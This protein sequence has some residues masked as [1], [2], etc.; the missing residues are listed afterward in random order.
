[1]NHMDANRTLTRYEL[2]SPLARHGLAAALPP[3]RD[4]RLAWVNSIC[5]LFLLTG[6][7]GYKR[8]TASIKPLTPIDDAVPAV[9]E[10]LPP[11]PPATAEQPREEPPD[12]DKPEVPQVVAVTL[13]APAINFS[14]PTI[15][16]LLV[17]NA[18][19]QAPPV[20]PLKPVAPL[21]SAPRTINSTGG[22]G[23]RPQPPYPKIA[24]EQGQ[25]GSVTLSLKAD[26]AG[27]ITDIEVAES[28]G[29]P[30]LD[31]S[32][33]E[34]VKHH[35]VVP[36]GEGARNYHATIHYRLKPD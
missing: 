31:R 26:D 15:G 30:L 1:M 9:V 25:Q 4:R 27:A 6:V 12:Q 5:I 10:P 29:F 36:P 20:S 8:G 24:L 23:D 33:L 17:A 13:D 16:N 19:A 14:V 18:L 35:W 32:A 7:I 34:F 28:S 11:P 22:G 3:D 21:R 2:T